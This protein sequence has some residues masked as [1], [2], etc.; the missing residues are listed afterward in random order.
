MSEIAARVV[1]Q[2]F[3]QERCSSSGHGVRR[4]PVREIDSD[5]PRR[6]A[7]PDRVDSSA[8]DWVGWAGHA[9]GRRLDRWGFPQIFDRPPPWP[10][11]LINR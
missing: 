11:G 1:S 6:M 4:K 8:N 5:P 7:C 9:S 10:Y 3:M 2:S